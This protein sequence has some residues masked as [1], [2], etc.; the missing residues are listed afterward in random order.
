[1]RKSLILIILAFFAQPV[2]AQDGGQANCRQ[3]IIYIWKR[4]ATN[5]PKEPP[6]DPAL[7]QPTEVVAMVL[8]E[9]GAK[10]EEVKARL[11][12]KLPEALASARALCQKA[13][14]SLGQC[15]AGKISSLSEELGRVDF[16]TRRT[17][18]E[19]V[20]ADCEKNSGICLEVKAREPKCVI[21]ENTVTPEPEAAPKDSKKK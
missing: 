1:M 5:T 21:I 4:L 15:T 9:E 11:A 12:D 7:Y 19:K 8:F 14:E 17:I 20:L 18:K 13:H 16:D 6:S 3:E 10:E 2:L